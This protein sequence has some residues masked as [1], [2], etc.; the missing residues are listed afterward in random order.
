MLMHSGTDV[1]RVAAAATLQHVV[2][3]IN[4]KGLG[5]TCVTDG[6][7][8]LA[9]TPQR[10]GCQEGS[11]ELAPVLVE[12]SHLAKLPELEGLV[13]RVDATVR[14]AGDADRVLCRARNHGV[15]VRQ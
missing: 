14:D 13:V 10:L 15:L 1:P 3:E 6:D 4:G 2:E 12:I 7:S 9:D 8:K 11:C 5:M